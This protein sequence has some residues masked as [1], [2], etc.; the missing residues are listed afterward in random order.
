[1]QQYRKQDEELWKHKGPACVIEQ[2][3][4]KLKSKAHELELHDALDDA[5]VEEDLRGLQS[6]WQAL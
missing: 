2:K 5:S 4:N 6:S 1:M 3:W